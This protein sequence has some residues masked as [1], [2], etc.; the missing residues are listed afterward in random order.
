MKSGYGPFLVNTHYLSE[1]VNAHIKK[2]NFE[3]YIRIV[4]E[5][6]L[7][8][9]AGTLIKNL[10]FYSQKDSLL[11]HVDNH[12][13]VD[14]KKFFKA[15]I[16][17]PKKSLM[18][19]MTFETNDP[20]NCG[21]VEIDNNNIIKKFHEKTKST[22]KYANGAIYLL[23]KEIQNE[24]KKNYGEAKDFSKDIIPHFINRISIFH[25]RSNFFDIGT[26]KNYNYLN[27]K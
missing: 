14:M 11:M 4:N 9:T 27:Q 1:K 24:I 7:L 21:I 3:K 18:T 2:S 15:H 22:G 26:I 6:K 17:R 13:D 25:T 16:N 8:G 10:P 19:M 5:K 12:C 20:I 23:S